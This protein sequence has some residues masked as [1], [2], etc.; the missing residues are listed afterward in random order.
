MSRT[1]DVIDLDGNPG[2][3]KLRRIEEHRAAGRGEWQDGVF[4][5]TRRVTSVHTLRHSP[6]MSVSARRDDPYQGGFLRYPVPY[7]VTGQPK[8]PGLAHKGAGL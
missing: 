5:F 8:Y 2:R 1:G 4:V 6:T 3:L 7:G